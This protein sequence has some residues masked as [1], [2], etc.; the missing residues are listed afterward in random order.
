MKH[1]LFV[2]AISATMILLAGSATFLCI[3]FTAYQPVK[4]ASLHDTSNKVDAKA[5]AD[6]QAARQAAEE[7]AAAAKAASEAA[8]KAAQNQTITTAT[9]SADKSVTYTVA[10]K[11]N[12]SS[13]LTEFKTL[14]AETLNDS[15]GWIRAGV[16]FQEVASGGDFNLVSIRSAISANVLVGL[17]G[18]L[19]LPRR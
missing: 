13:S 8:K 16:H 11:G 18:Q 10:I 9:T 6:H 17:L 1:W 3:K 14:A 4:L 5:L 19:E 7:K 12:P 2:V 15:R